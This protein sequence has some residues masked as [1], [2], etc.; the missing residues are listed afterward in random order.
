MTDKNIIRSK[1]ILKIIMMNLGKH[2]L[3]MNMIIIHDIVDH[4]MNQIIGLNGIVNFIEDFI[5][6]AHKFSMIDEQN[7]KRKERGKNVINH[8]QV[9][10][11]TLYVG[12]RWR[13][14]EILHNTRKKLINISIISSKIVKEKDIVHVKIILT[15]Q[16]ISL[17]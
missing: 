11:D 12:V 13:K 3:S 9:E 5:E 8:S 7:L 2:P 4:L 15:N 1:I 10:L 16:M 6:E 14:V 17:N